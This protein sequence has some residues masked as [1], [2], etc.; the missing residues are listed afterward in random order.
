LT[1]RL[2][3]WGNEIPDEPPKV[4]TKKPRKPVQQKMER[5]PTDIVL[6]LSR[7]CP[8][9]SA[10]LKD[11]RLVLYQRRDCGIYKVHSAGESY[12]GEQR[13]RLIGPESAVLIVSEKARHLLLRSLCR[14][15]K[16]GEA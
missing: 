13:L 4:S 7:N 9:S 14:L 3:L 11:L 2:D 12:A 1:L 5:E 15:R 6:W 10:A 16:F 8:S